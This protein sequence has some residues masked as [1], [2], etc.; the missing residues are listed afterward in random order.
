MTNYLFIDSRDP[1]EITRSPVNGIRLPKMK[2]NTK[3]NRI[4]L[5]LKSLLIPATLLAVAVFLVSAVAAAGLRASGSTSHLTR[6]KTH[7]DDD[8]EKFLFV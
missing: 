7:D 1:F 6:T 2:E 8:R 5:F 3:M 4:Q